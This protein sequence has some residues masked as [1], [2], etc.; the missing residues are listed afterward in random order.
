MPERCVK[1]ASHKGDALR[2]HLLFIKQFKINIISNHNL[3]LLVPPGIISFVVERF[4][5]KNS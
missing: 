2:N 1:D 3:R 4:L 5:M